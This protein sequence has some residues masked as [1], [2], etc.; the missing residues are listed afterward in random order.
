MKHI[1]LFENW[2]NESVSFDTITV[3]MQNVDDND[4]NDLMHT[5]KNEDVDFYIFYE[6]IDSPQCA[7]LDQRMAVSLLRELDSS[8]KEKLALFATVEVDPILSDMATSVFCVK[9]YWTP[10]ITDRFDEC[11]SLK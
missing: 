10:M 2:I 8:H 9:D 1:K 3:D 11:F 5:I 4:L 7:I 6:D